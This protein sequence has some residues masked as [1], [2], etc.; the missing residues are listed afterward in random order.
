M[1]D[2][3]SVETEEFDETLF[4]KNMQENSFEGVETEGKGT[5]QA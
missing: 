4:Q 1:D 3:F 2:Q 5:D